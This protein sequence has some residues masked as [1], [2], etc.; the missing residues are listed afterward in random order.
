MGQVVKL[1]KIGFPFRVDKTESGIIIT[2][3]Y[4]V[5]H[6]FND[7]EWT[8][9]MEKSLDSDGFMLLEIT[10]PELKHVFPHDAQAGINGYTQFF[11][12]IP[13]ASSHGV[14]KSIYEYF[15]RDLDRRYYV[16]ISKEGVDP[17][18]IQLGSLNDPKSK[19]FQYV[20]IV[21]DSFK[22][23]EKFDRK[24]LEPVL[25]KSLRNRRIVKA[26]L[27]VLTAEGFL[28]KTEIQQRGKLYE[29][30]EKT[31]K[32]T[33]FAIDSKWHPKPNGISVGQAMPTSSQ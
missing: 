32:L 17:F 2:D 30:F 9:I 5:S 31:D 20:Q 4:A 6:R 25:S 22:T 18:K 29:Q 11:S 14:L 23:N 8:T 26:M 13:K 33:K 21:Q 7:G 19:I 10:R 28:K 16:C 3:C 24:K 1:L 15:K 12:S 27:D